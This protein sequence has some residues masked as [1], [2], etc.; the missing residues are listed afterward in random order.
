MT[1][2]N[3][4]VTD[5]LDA[6]DSAEQDALNLVLSLAARFGWGSLLATRND[7]DTALQGQLED[8]TATLTDDEWDLVSQNLA[9]D[10]DLS[11]ET[12]WANVEFAVTASLP[13]ERLTPTG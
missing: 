7:A 11:M 2:L 4:A 1:D 13:T 8:D 10:D 3:A 12:F 9:L 5:A 6:S